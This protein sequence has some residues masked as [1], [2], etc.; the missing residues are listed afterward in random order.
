M[1][2]PPFIPLRVCTIAMWEMNTGSSVSRRC[3]T[4]YVVREDLEKLHPWALIAEACGQ[5]NTYILPPFKHIISFSHNLRLR[6]S[7][8][9]LISACGLA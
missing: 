5:T 3:S 8:S 1:P 7:K 4:L 9:L 6:E 2:L